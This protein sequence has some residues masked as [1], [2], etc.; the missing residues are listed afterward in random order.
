M[1]KRIKRYDIFYNDSAS[2]GSITFKD[3]SQAE[4]EASIKEEINNNNKNTNPEYHISRSSFKEC[5]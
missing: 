1:I 2:Y 4:I 5:K 3:A